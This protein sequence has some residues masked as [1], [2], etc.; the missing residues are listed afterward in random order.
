MSSNWNTKYPN[1]VIGIDLGTTNSC[2]GVW[3]IDTHRVV[4][5]SNSEGSR[6][7][8]SFVSFTPSERL[9]GDAAKNQAALNP[10][11]TI[12]DVKRIIGRKFSEPLVQR[13]IAS[14]PFTVISDD[15]DQ[16]LIKIDQ[17]ICPSAKE[18]Y[19]PEEISAMVL[20]R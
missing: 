11:N 19:T 2:V 5:I 3:D 12:F 1:T 10:K 7:T 9:V 14:W 17:S 20:A 18:Y 6:T 16:P 13:D 8:P 4:I 15:N